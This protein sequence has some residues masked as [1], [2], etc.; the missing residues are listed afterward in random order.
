LKND[1]LPSHSSERRGYKRK[2]LDVGAEASF[3]STSGRSW[4]D[5]ED[6]Q[7]RGQ[8]VYPAAVDMVEGKAE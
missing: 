7:P 2:L 8:E 6:V 4:W 3:L 1:S 5:G